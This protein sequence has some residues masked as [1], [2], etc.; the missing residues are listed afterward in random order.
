VIAVDT[1]VLVYA[2]RAELPRHGAARALLRALA[3][4]DEPWALPW[5]CIYEFLRVVTHP[6]VFDPPTDL[7]AALEDLA[8][9]VA[10]PSLV[11][12]GEGP[13]HFGHLRAAMTDGA[14]VG[15]LAH[16]A[17][18]AALCIEHGVRELLTADRDFARFGGVR[19]RNPFA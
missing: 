16:D 17:H 14:A 10:S 8:S 1:N 7:G 15:N 5:P 9:L 11:L 6:R 19:L 13:S 2:R 3:E 12:L 4:G 18:I